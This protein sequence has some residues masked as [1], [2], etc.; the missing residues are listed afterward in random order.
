[1]I[2]RILAGAA[3]AAVALGFSAS[4]ASADQPNANN[5]GQAVLSQFQVTDDVLN[6]WFNNSLNGA[7]RDTEVSLVKFLYLEEVDLDLLTNNQAAVT[8]RF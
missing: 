8:P 2:S 7:L 6:N 1:M 5:S 3:I 4:S